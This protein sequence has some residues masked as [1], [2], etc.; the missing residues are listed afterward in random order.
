MEDLIALEKF[1]DL[2]AKKGVDFGKGNPYNRLRY[3]TK[4][5]LLPHMRRKVVNG[6]VLGHYPSSAL[7][8]LVEVEKLKGLGLD[9]QAIAKKIATLSANT[10]SNA[11]KVARALTPSSRVLKLVFLALFC[12]VVFAG[13][14]F[15]PVGKSR[16]DL[17]QKTLELDKTYIIDSGSAYL[18]KDQSKVYIK[19]QSVKLTSKINVSFSQNY[20]PA[21]RYW[22]A[23]KVPFEG[24][25]LELDAPT[26]ADAEFS[27]WVSN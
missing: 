26:S 3:Y 22:V 18:P 12:L 17:I 10:G 5:G 14:G 20:S 23:Q 2:A 9:N 7:D 19:S 1:I 6:E 16:A 24:F 8:T 4:L 13:L 21:V 27:W 15:L 11:I 25:Y